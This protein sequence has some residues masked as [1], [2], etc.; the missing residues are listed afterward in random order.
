LIPIKDLNPSKKAPVVTT[1]LILFCFLVFFY[2][3]Y[4]PPGARERFIQMFA[5]IPFEIAR[6]VDIPPPDPLTPYGNTVSY[7]YLHGGFMHIL[8]NMLF[9]WVFGD[10]VEERFGHL[11]Y[12]LFYTVCGVAAALTQVF[13]TPNST[14][15][16]IGASGAISGV[17]G[18][19]AVLFPRAGIVTLVFIFFFV[20]VIVVP[21]L[22]WIA[23]WFL[24]QFVSAMVSVDHL[25]LG[26]VAWFAHIGGFLTGIFLTKLF[27]GKKA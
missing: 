5:V 24:L 11:R 23:V 10:N 2:E 22:V 7:Q 18:A 1:L 3:L 20:D 17:L 12:F 15:P 26:G 6:G 19:Y 27:L 13:V 14:L 16:L 9:L 8:G 25:S 4:L 21:A